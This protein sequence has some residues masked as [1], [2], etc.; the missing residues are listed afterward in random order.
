MSSNSNI[1]QLMALSSEADADDGDRTMCESFFRYLLFV[2]I[3]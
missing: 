2:V 1:T 3:L